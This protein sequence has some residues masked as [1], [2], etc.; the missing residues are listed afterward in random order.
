LCCCKAKARAIAQA[1]SIARARAGP[2]AVAAA[3]A[4][5]ISRTRGVTAELAPG[6]CDAIAIAPAIGRASIPVEGIAIAIA[7]PRARAIAQSHHRGAATGN[8]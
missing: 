5:S 6:G 2:G 4:A 8:T 7:V 1:R 3:E